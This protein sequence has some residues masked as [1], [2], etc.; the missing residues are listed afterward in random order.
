MKSENLTA[1]IKCT[2]YS[3][4]HFNESQFIYITN[5]ELIGCGGNQ[6]KYVKN[7]VIKNTKFKGVESSRTALEMIETTADI[8][9]S[10][11]VSNR[12]GSYRKCIQFGDGTH[13]SVSF[14]GGYIGGAIIAKNSIINISQSMFEDNGVDY[15]RAIFVEQHCTIYMSKTIFV[16]NYARNDGGVIISSSSESLTSH[17]YC[18]SSDIKSIGSSNITITECKFYSNK[19]AN[20]GGVLFSRGNDFIIIKKSKFYNNRARRNGGIL[21]TFGFINWWPYHSDYRSE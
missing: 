3:Q 17:S 5:L 12:N 15:G 1:Q 13:K 9:N 19:A 11:F 4:F 7:L 6:V 18:N 2:S 21:Q 10:T 14:P 16:S 8:V 20:R